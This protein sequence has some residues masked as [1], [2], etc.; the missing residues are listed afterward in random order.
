MVGNTQT[1]DEY[2]PRIGFHWGNRFGKC[3][4]ACSN[5][6]KFMDNNLDAY[7]NIYANKVFAP[8]GFWKESD[9]RLKTNV[10]PLE[11]T[12]EQICAIPTASFIMNDKEQIGTI[13]QDIEELGFTEIVE[14]IETPASEVKDK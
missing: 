4:I 9:I 14:D 8:N 10:K 5:G 12:I 7:E 11:H 2:A 6:F 1:S 13:A 3:L